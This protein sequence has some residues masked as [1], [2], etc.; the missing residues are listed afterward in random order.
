MAMKPSSKFGKMSADDRTPE[1]KV[2]DY[3]KVNSSKY[4]SPVTGTVG[5]KKVTSYLAPNGNEVR[6]TAGDT[7]ARKNRSRLNALK[8]MAS[9][10]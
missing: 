10:K 9:S 2:R 5:G 6:Y 7:K 4:G 8:K 1:Q 3:Q